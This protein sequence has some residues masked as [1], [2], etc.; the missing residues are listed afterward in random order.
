M[1]AVETLGARAG[2]AGGLTSAMSPPTQYRR[3]IGV[4]VIAVLMCLQAVVGV[5]SGLVL[6]L[7]RHDPQLLRETKWTSG[8]VLGAGIAVLALAV[9]TMLLAYLLARGSNAVR[10]LVALVAVLQLAASGYALA[11]AAVDHHRVGG[12]SSPE[13]IATCVIALVVLLILFAEPGSREFF[14]GRRA[15]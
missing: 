2:R 6:V 13:S 12:I 1:T 8:N 11:R 7:G 10:W 5:M 3:P 15:R 14:T 4:T 9:L